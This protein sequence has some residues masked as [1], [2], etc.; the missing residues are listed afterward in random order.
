VSL[1]EP[2][3]EEE[4]EEEEG[5]REAEGQEGP[6]HL[7]NAPPSKILKT[8]RHSSSRHY[9]ANDRFSSV[10]ATVLEEEGEE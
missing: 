9:R 10:P 1:V 4:E 8:G 2:I 6:T 3:T 5:R 7:Q